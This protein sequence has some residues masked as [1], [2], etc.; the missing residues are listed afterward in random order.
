[1]CRVGRVRYCSLKFNYWADIP[2]LSFNP[3]TFQAWNIK[4]VEEL[5]PSQQDLL[6]PENTEDWHLFSTKA[7]V[8][9]F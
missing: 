3:V 2:C 4:T 6:R 5:L 7:K 1:M 9:P 8:K